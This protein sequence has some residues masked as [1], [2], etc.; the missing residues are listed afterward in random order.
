M[1]FLAFAALYGIMSVEQTV[2]QGG[3]RRMRALLKRSGEES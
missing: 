1:G 2:E 3:F